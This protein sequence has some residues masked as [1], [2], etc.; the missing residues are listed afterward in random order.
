MTIADKAR[1][2]LVPHPSGYLEYQLPIS[3]K[4]AIIWRGLVP[5]LKNERDEWELPGGKLEVDEDPKLALEREIDEELSWKVSVGEPFHAWVYQ[6]RPDRHVFV[7]SY[8][9][10]YN[11]TAQPAYSH[12]HKELLL[13]PVRDVPALNMPHPYKEAISLAAGRLS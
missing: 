7:L 10:T 4:A 13:V 11:G 12:E 6:I 3:L 5:L 1:P 2:Y 9:A 8:L